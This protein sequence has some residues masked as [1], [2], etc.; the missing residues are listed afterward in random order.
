MNTAVAFAIFAIVLILIV[1]GVWM[2]NVPKY[3]QV[4]NIM[5]V[6]TPLS[7]S[8][9][10]EVPTLRS[11]TVKTAKKKKIVVREQEEHEPVPRKKEIVVA[12]HSPV[13]EDDNGNKL[14]DFINYE[15]PGN[16]VTDV[17]QFYGRIIDS[18]VV[19]ETEYRHFLYLD[20]KAIIKDIPIID[21]TAYDDKLLFVVS[22]TFK[23]Y[24]YDTR[25]AIMLDI[26]SNIEV[27]QVEHSGDFL[28][29]ISN[30]QLYRVAL[31]KNLGINSFPVKLDWTHVETPQLTQVSHIS[32]ATDGSLWV[33]SVR[34]G[35]YIDDS[36]VHDVI[37][38]NR[39]YLGKDRNDTQETRASDIP[40]MLFTKEGWVENTKNV[41]I[42]KTILGKDLT[43]R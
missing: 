20:S 39:I 7:T 5:P 12:T 38:G 30:G 37:V 31:M 23:H 40:R 27:E 36:E 15:S 8:K 11:I 22:D 10:I 25:N 24:I 43:L 1:F 9:K 3:E 2:V 14:S 6:F 4:K 33:Q 13:Y 35:M 29:A 16:F 41:L 17:D 19:R 21:F 32:T 42:S 28:Y 18:P 34:R 26:D